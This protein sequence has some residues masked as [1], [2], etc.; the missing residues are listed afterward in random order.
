MFFLSFS[1]PPGQHRILK[2]FVLIGSLRSPNDQGGVDVQLGEID[3]V[4]DEADR[5]RR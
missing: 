2:V 4:P 5:R 3:Q 1:T